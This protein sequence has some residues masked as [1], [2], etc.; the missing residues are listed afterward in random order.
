MTLAPEEEAWV[1]R[2]AKLVT[3]M[4]VALPPPVVPRFWVPQPT[5]AQASAAQLEPA[6]PRMRVNKILPGFIFPTPNAIRFFT[7]ALQ[8]RCRW[9]PCF[10]IL[11]K[12]ASFEL[13]RHW[14]ER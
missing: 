2:S 8:N 13:P 1:C 12:P 9:F 5:G 11:E 14:E 6:K 3:V 4:G 7:P 10:S